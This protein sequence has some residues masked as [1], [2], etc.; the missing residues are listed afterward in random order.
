[1]EMIVI[2]TEGAVVRQEGS[3]AVQQGTALG[4]A[5]EDPANEFTVI[6]RGLGRLA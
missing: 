3:G 4:A 2:A 6:L 1:M 5:E